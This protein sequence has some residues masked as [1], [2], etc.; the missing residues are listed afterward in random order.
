MIPSIKKSKTKESQKFLRAPKGMHDVLPVD[1]PYWER[2]EKVG[3]ELAHAYGFNRIDTPIL[4][5]VELFQR[6]VGEETDLV[7][8][9]MFTIPGKSGTLVLRPE[10]TAPVARAY[11]EHNLGRAQQ[12][13]KLYY[14]GPM[15]RHENP[16]LGRYRQFSQF[17]FEI[18]GGPNDPLC[19]AQVILIFQRY[20]ENLKIKNI[21][22]KINSIG[23][24]VCQ[25]L[26]KRQLQNYYKHYEKELCVDCQRRL[27]TNPL[28]LLDCK[29]ESCQPFKEK[30]PNFL[31]KICVVCSRHLKG[32]FE[33]L[34]EL[35]IPYLL[36]N[37]L[38]RGLDYYSRTVFEFSVEG[39][40]SEIG[41]ILGGGRYD[42]LMELLG[43]RL[44]PA[45]GG[46]AGFER[47]I[48]VM[49]LQ[50]VKLPARTVKKVFF[51]HV[52]DLAKKKS[53][54][55]IEELRASGIPVIEALVKDSLKAQLKLADREGATT[56]L[57]FGQKEIYEKSVILRD[58]ES[59]LQE[60]IPLD[61]IVAEIKKRWRESNHPLT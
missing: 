43:G 46:S 36:S 49:K 45:V 27:K 19:D 34:D 29:V 35:S 6:T 18:I 10:G 31:D 57:I 61:K 25:P 4:E 5:H 24:R 28:R 14:F 42:Y 51:A 39:P 30:A 17:C 3:K 60:S 22:L 7:Q 47:L 44:T 52:G 48:G 8:K 20:L 37:Q 16:Q 26:F 56:A 11:L 59:G 13:Q 23:C 12:P 2:I 15:F 53:L 50:D 32:V 41:A 9:E 55:V 21:V 54:K 38:V 33:F 40:G 1:Q 58:L